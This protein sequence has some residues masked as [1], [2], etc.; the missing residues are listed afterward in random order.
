MDRV[1]VLNEIGLAS[2]AAVFAASPLNVHDH[3]QVKETSV[4]IGFGDMVKLGMVDITVN[5]TGN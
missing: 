5:S 2:A 1:S 3:P 4:P